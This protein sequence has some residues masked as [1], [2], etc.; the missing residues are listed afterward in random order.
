MMQTSIRRAAQ[1][2]SG[3]AALP[4][5]RTDSPRV[6]HRWPRRVRG[7]CPE[8]V[9]NHGVGSGGQ[10]RIDSRSESG[11]RSCP[12]GEDRRRPIRVNRTSDTRIFSSSE[13]R[14]RREKAEERE[15]VFDGPTELPRPTEPMPNPGCADRRSCDVSSRSARAPVHR[16][17]AGTEPHARLALSF[18]DR[19]TQGLPLQYGQQ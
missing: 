14:V 11:Q 4:D 7:R 1:Q 5:A 15:R 6:G 12:K 10:G 2:S 16:D 9:A 13:S 3:G 17:Q 18:T 8:P 19:R